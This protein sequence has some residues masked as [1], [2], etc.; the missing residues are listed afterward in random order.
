MAE[1]PHASATALFT[2]CYDT[3]AVIHPLTDIALGL[4]N[5]L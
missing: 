4:K 1:P 3:M 5:A 2:T